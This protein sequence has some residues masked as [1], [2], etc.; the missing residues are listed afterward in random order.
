MNAASLSSPDAIRRLADEYGSLLKDPA[1]PYGGWCR[2]LVEHLEYVAKAPLEVRSSVEFHQ[3]LW[4]DDVVA[5]TG[6]GSV[7][8]SKALANS[9]FRAWL[10]ARS[11]EPIPATEGERAAHLRELYRQL[12][13][14]V[15][16]FAARTPRLKIFRVLASLYPHSF[17]TVADIS[18]LEKLHRAMLPGKR[19]D[20]VERHQEVLSRLDEVLGVVPADLGQWVARM[21]LPWR[22]VEVLEAAEGPSATAVSP[23]TTA[24]QPLPAARRRRGLTSI[25][26]YYDSVVRILELVGE[27]VSRDDLHDLVKQENPT[28]KSN[29][30]GVNINVLRSELGV[31]ERSG[32]RYEPTESGRQLL[33]KDDPFVLAPW[34][35]TR[36]LGVDHVLAYLRDHPAVPAA[37][38]VRV[39]QSANPGWTSNFA[40]QAMLSWLRSFGTI[41]TNDE[42]RVVLTAHGREW[43]ELVTW[44]PECLRRSDDDDEEDFSAPVGAAPGAETF[45]VPALEEVVKRLP[46]NL[47]F[48]KDQIAA[49]HAGLWS[50]PRRHFAILTGLSGSGKTS[51]AQAYGEAIIA[52]TARPTDPPKRLLLVPVAPG[53][54]DPSAL[55]GY[56]NPLR[57]GEYVATE[58]VHFLVSCSAHP[59]AIH[60]AVLDEMNLSHPEQYLAPLLSRMEV[61]GKAIVFHHEGAEIDGIPEQIPGYPP[62]LVLFG[63]VNMDETTHGVSDKV[64]DRALTMEFWNIDL[65]SY[66]GWGK[67]GLPEA[68]EKRIREVLS[69]LMQALAPV[70]LHFGWR[71]VADVLGFVKRAEGDGSLPLEAALDWIVYSKILPKL[72]GYDSPQFRSA[73]DRCRVELEKHGLPRSRDKLAELHRDLQET[74]SARFWR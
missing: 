7:D 74:G 37:D 62:N 68:Q 65:D 12:T 35:V 53:W 34:L 52:A 41:E 66:P 44:E 31:L 14:R 48:A 27:G 73:F 45:A 15:R 23:P 61:D 21:T 38:L 54:T 58:F 5:A 17:T 9:E 11:L 13:E 2:R 4:D 46:G 10:A 8:V 20:E 47:A 57:S 60:V 1:R 33:A 19:A 69:D 49:L 71:I 28:L 72:R 25:K 55:L 50:H 70:R 32:D 56:L 29:S 59:S 18:R 6:Q 40:P 64:L 42:G 39:L 22:L 67:S 43:A 30:V 3:R 26:G 63:T 16:Q 51:L 24:L 36:I